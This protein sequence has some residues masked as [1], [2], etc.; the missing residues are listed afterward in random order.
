MFIHQVFHVEVSIETNSSIC[1]GIKFHDL[2]FTISIQSNFNFLTRVWTV[3]FIKKRL[4][5]IFRGKVHLAGR[6]DSV[7]GGECIIGVVT[8]TEA[9]FIHVLKYL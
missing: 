7:G 9:L 8:I 6:Y 2:A 3:H 5:E 1:G 4:F